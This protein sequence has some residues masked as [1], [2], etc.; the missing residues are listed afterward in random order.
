MYGNHTPTLRRLTI[1]VLSQIA[2]SSACERNWITFALI[3]TKQRNWLA[4]PMLQHLV[5][6]CYN[7]KL[8][9]R[10]MEAKNDKVVEKDYLDLLDIAVGVGE[11]EEDNQ[12]FQ[13]VRP[14]H[15]DDENG[16]PNHELLHMFEKQVLML[17]RC[18]PKKFIL[19]VSSKTQ[20]IHFH[21]EFLCR[22]SLLDLFLTPQV[23]NIVVDLVLLV[24]S[25]PVMMVQE[26]RGPMMVATLEMMKGMLDNNNKVDNHW[27]LLVKMI[28]HIV[29][30]MKTMALEEPVQVLEPLESHIEEDNEG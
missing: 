22:Q 30:K 8:K 24:L 4:F 10:D 27:H 1:K 13:W 16:N 14:L 20:E 6:Y 25:L 9:I 19:I 21:K 23:L 28:S 7:M 2:S 12:L 15:L 18:Y 11:E 5:F 3:H 29:L 17:I 26:E